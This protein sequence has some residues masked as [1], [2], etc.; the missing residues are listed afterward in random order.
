[1]CKSQQEFV[2]YVREFTVSFKDILPSRGFN[3]ISSN[4]TVKTV[5]LLGSNLFVADLRKRR[6]KINIQKGKWHY[7]DSPAEFTFITKRYNSNKIIIVAHAILFHRET[8]DE[9]FRVYVSPQYRCGKIFLNIPHIFA[10]E[11]IIRIDPR[12]RK[13]TDTRIGLADVLIYEFCKL[14]RSCKLQLQLDRQAA[15]LVFRN[16]FTYT[17]TSPD[18]ELSY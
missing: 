3:F 9:I 12:I 2:S 7:G 18:W 4:D 8:Y 1:M 10:T 5:E 11:E 17:G 6:S 13:Y 14:P 16:G 15:W